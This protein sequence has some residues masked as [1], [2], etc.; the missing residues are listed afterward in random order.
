[1]E[2]LYTETMLKKLN[3]DG[4]LKITAENEIEVPEGATNPQIIELILAKACPL[5][6]ED[7]MSAED[8]SAPKY[9]KEQILKSSWYS[10]KRD[11]LSGLLEDGKTYSFA[12]VERLIAK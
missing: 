12:T 3:K 4:L 7:V 2:N 1:M 11:A 9:A 10:H 6:A 5:L 8:K